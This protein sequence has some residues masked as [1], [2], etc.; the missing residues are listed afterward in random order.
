MPVNNKLAPSHLSPFLDQKRLKSS[1]NRVEMSGKEYQ[2]LLIFFWVCLGLQKITPI[3]NQFP[4]TVQ[5]ISSE[6]FVKM[7]SY[8]IEA[9]ESAEVGMMCSAIENLYDIFSK[10]DPLVGCPI[11]LTFEF[12]KQSS[13]GMIF[14][15]DV[16]LETEPSNR[17]EEERH[18][19]SKKIKREIK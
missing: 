2:L 4:D 17:L 3:L 13:V 11:R 10:A 18:L 19:P 6:Y 16:D 5:L 1:K 12:D 15:E 9:T 7:Y 14:R 8:L